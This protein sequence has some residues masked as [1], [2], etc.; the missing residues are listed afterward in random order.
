MASEKNNAI[1]V[2]QKVDEVAGRVAEVERLLRPD[3][4]KM[5]SLDSQLGALSK[6][7]FVLLTEPVAHANAI[8]LALVKILL[9]QDFD[10]IYVT[11]N[12]E[13]DTWAREFAALEIPFSRVAFVDGA[14]KSPRFSGMRPPHVFTLEHSSDLAETLDAID[15]AGEKLGEHKQCVV[16]DSLSTLLIFSHLRGVQKFTHVLRSH[17]HDRGMAGI[18][19]IGNEGNA[20]LVHSVSPFFDR[21]IALSHV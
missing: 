15:A 16:L 4:T 6:T 21:V 19:L 18:V 11:Y 13:S 9:S 17:L 12:R 14:S 3:I 5:R 1:G 7:D 8:H 10:V 2:S 20:S